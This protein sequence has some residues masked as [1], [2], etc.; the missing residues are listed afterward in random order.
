MSSKPE[1]DQ[2]ET[3]HEL[4][5]TVLRRILFEEDR[6][7]QEH[8]L[9]DWSDEIDQAIESI[10]SAYAELGLFRKSLDGN[11]R[12]ATVE[13]F[14]HSANYALI[15]ALHHLTTGYPVAA[16]HMMRHFDESFAMAALCVDPASQVL[17]QFSENRGTY[18]VDKAPNKL[19][20]PKQAS[21]LVDL[22]GFDPAGW[23]ERLEEN[24]DFSG[25]SHAGGLTLAFQLMLDTE[26]LMVVGGQYDPAKANAYRADLGRITAAAHD[27]GVFTNAATAALAKEP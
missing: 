6:E 25:R 20:R 16:G 3:L 11:P 19:R 1:G 17:E 12:I 24:K 14:V 21:R 7:N 5:P 2:P 4:T 23:A 10:V 18:R 26:D 22:V 27:L 13:A 15:A 9:A 8:F